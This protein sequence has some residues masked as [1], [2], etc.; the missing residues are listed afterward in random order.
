MDEVGKDA[1]A[2]VR[3]EVKGQ[4]VEGEGANLRLRLA[5]P[6]KKPKYSGST[7]TTRLLSHLAPKVAKPKALTQFDGPQRFEFHRCRFRNGQ[8]RHDLMTF[9]LVIS[10]L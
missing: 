3:L 2:S 4:R 1:A 6:P 10:P 5:P 9:T 8:R 7:T